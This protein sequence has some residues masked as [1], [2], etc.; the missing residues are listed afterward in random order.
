MSVNSQSHTAF[1]SRPHVQ[2][3]LY[4]LEGELEQVDREAGLDYLPMDVYIDALTISR[5][6]QESP[7]RKRLTRTL[8]GKS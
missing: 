6:F 5:H 8:S 7:I 4:L 3:M 2:G 1:T